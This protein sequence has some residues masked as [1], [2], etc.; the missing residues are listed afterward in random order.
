MLQ[1]SPWP[2]Y[3]RRTAFA[4]RP[5]LTKAGPRLQRGYVT[6]PSSLPSPQT[7][8]I[9][10]ERSKSSRSSTVRALD[11]AGGANVAGHCIADGDIFATRLSTPAHP[12]TG[13]SAPASQDAGSTLPR[14]RE[15]V[16]AI[17][18][19]LPQKSSR[20]PLLASSIAARYWHLAGDERYSLRRGHQ[21]LCTPFYDTHRLGHQ[22]KTVE[23]ALRGTLLL[24]DRRAKHEVRILWA[25]LHTLP[26][27]K[28]TPTTI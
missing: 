28:L 14:T 5:R 1:A 9:S 8:S 2:Q 17:A 20:W 7:R 15:E 24:P 10:L 21:H 3:H 22:S 12:A 4:L 18:S 23:S 25:A 26:R 11:L 19:V 13:P 6:S 16:L 27:G